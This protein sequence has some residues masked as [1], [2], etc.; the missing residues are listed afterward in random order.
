MT[1]VLYTVCGALVYLPKYS[2]LLDDRPRAN[3]SQKFFFSE[4]LLLPVNIQLKYHL[5]DVKLQQT[6]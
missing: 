3:D 6:K 2:Y 4:G 5:S 1:G